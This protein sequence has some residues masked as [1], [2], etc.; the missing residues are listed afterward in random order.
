MS[1]A[2]MVTRNVMTPVIKMMRKRRAEA[3]PSA[4]GPESRPC[5]ERRAVP[6]PAAVSGAGSGTD[7]AGAGWSGGFAP[8]LAMDRL[9]NAAVKDIGD[10]GEAGIRNV[11]LR[12][13][14]LEGGHGDEHQFDL[15][16]SWIKSV[17]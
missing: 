17:E 2:S 5:Q 11:H 14:G 8:S 16:F 10:F 6:P 1:T 7:A 9:Q 12:G 13:D 3:R 4:S 15:G